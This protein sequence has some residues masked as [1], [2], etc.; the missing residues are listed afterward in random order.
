MSDLDTLLATAATIL[1]HAA[2]PRRL[3]DARSVRRRREPDNP[4]ASGT[5]V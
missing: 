2:P 1:D 3:I 5:A 4:R